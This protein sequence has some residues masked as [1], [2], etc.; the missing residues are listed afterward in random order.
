[1]DGYFPLRLL[2]SC[3][4]FGV[5]LLAFVAAAAG[6]GAVAPLILPARLARRSFAAPLGG[7]VVFLF[8][9]PPS[10]GPLGA[11]S[12]SKLYSACIYP[13]L[14]QF[15][16]YD[17]EDNHVGLYVSVLLGFEAWRQLHLE[18]LPMSN[19]NCIINVASASSVTPAKN[20]NETRSNI[21][22]VEEH[23]L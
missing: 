9:L 11:A 5:C 10:G 19:K 1:M 18:C 17:L 22:E 21:Y 6:V 14:R 8:V 4:A 23:I 7:C 16:N 15:V 2:F 13:V 3:C 12:A 20:Y